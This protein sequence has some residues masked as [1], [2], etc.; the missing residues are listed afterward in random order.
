M[1]GF[2]GRIDMDI[3]RMRYCELLQGERHQQQLSREKVKQAGSSTERKQYRAKHPRRSV[4][5]TS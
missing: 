1:V 4:R 5:V 3:A 2:W